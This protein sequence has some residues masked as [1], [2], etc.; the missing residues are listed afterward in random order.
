MKAS[1]IREMNP[2]ERLQNLTDL[3]EALFNLRF[4]LE[5]GQIENPNKIKQ[6]KNDI[7]RLKTVIRET[8]N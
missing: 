1:E 3:K 4:Q 8:D 5:I 6:T 2:E 7:A